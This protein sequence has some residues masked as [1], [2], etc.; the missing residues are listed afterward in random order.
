MV[1]APRRRSA[2]LTP[3]W[4]VREF[5]RRPKGGEA[6]SRCSPR[7]TGPRSE[8]TEMRPGYASYVPLEIFFLP[9]TIR[10]RL[11]MNLRCINRIMG[12]RFVQNLSREDTGLKPSYRATPA[13]QSALSMIFLRRWSAFLGL[14]TQD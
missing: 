10:L 11:G 14:K 4:T 7:L 5:R 1:A 6:G 2:L 9:S 12:Y 3:K 13:C 8:N